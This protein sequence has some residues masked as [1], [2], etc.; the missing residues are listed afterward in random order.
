[1]L[2]DEEYWQSNLWYDTIRE[3]F[4]VCFVA[5]VGHAVDQAVIWIPRLRVACLWRSG[6]ISRLIFKC[7]AKFLSIVFFYH[8]VVVTNTSVLQVLLF[9]DR[10]LALELLLVLFYWGLDEHASRLLSYSHL[11]KQ[12]HL[13]REVCI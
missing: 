9:V 6:V 11:L 4:N 2:G 5:Y 10:L 12:R 13:V 3:L 1:M 7:S 8:D